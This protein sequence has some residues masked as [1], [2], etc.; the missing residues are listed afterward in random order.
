MTNWRVGFFRLW[1][2]LSV[3][4]VVL[5][6]LLTVPN[7]LNP[8]ITD[9]HFTVDDDGQLETLVPGTDRYQAI[10]AELAAQRYQLVDL[11]GVA[12][13]VSYY[14][15]NLV[16]IT[17]RERKYQVIASTDN[18]ALSGRQTLIDT[19]TDFI[20]TNE[21]GSV[22]S[23]VQAE[24]DATVPP[25]VAL[26][27][28]TPEMAIA[29][30]DYAVRLHDSAVAVARSSQVVPALLYFTLPPLV[31]LALGSALGWVLSGFRRERSQA[32]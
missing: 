11:P 10:R 8:Y 12:P 14:A 26:K 30:K 4:W 17:V 32:S 1:L 21:P 3:L 22:R 25:T 6:A 24:V 2:L 28:K 15:P 9:L 31:L 7:Y 29:V 23:V 16:E 27:Y 20:V 18:L 13:A 19:L 5:V